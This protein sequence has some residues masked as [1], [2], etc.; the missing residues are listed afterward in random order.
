MSWAAIKLLIHHWDLDMTNI[1]SPSAATAAAASAA[2]SALATSTVS[3]LSDEEP[4][5]TQW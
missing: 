1:I 3:T 4:F 2:S 5:T